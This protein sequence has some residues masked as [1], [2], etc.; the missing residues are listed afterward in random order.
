MIQIQLNSFVHRASDKLKL[1]AAV[2]S[3]GAT[4]K[5]IRRSRNWLLSGTEF[6]LMA[7]KTQLGDERDRWIKL[8]IEKGMPVEA[9]LAA[10]EAQLSALIAQQTGITVS[11]LVALS[12]C[13]VADARKA[14]DSHEDLD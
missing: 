6:Q 14:I 2:E 4:L 10:T 11:E 5:R 12:G 9:T 8:A 3:T 7:L 13:S 1:L